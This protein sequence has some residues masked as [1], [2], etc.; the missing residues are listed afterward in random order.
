MKRWLVRLVVVALIALAALGLRS[1][2]LRPQSVEVATVAIDRGSV[3]LTI[4]NTRVDEVVRVV[5][6]VN[7]MVVVTRKFKTSMISDISD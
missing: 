3:E 6:V 1:W 4:T 2:V 7:N 5:K